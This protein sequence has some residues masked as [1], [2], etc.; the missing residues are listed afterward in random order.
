M[1]YIDTVECMGDMYINK[2]DET[3]YELI[4]GDKT[5]EITSDD[6]YT[7]CYLFD[8]EDEFVSTYGYKP[9]KFD[10]YEFVSNNKRIGELLMDI[11]RNHMIR[12]I[13]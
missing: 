6:A 7:I 8:V 1:I 12:R 3:T 2:K 10:L 4:L 9:E 11:I 13:K 5:I